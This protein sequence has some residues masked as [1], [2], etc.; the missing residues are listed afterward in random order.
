M[1]APYT[2][3]WAIATVNRLRLEMMQAIRHCRPVRE[4]VAIRNRI[5]ALQRAYRIP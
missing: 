2:R 5:E 4:R 3:E 1:P